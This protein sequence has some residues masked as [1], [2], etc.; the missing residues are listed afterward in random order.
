M[1]CWPRKRIHQSGL[2]DGGWNKTTTEG[3]IQN[4][5]L[6]DEQKGTLKPASQV[7]TVSCLEVR[8]KLLSKYIFKTMSFLTPRFV[9]PWI[10][11]TFGKKRQRKSEV[12]L[13]SRL[14]SEKTTKEIRGKPSLA[15]TK[16]FQHANG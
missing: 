1:Y 10:K 15:T 14:H 11:I 6:L 9:R 12:N 7:T 3:N 8:Y 16:Y 13:G 5:C 2:D 4:L